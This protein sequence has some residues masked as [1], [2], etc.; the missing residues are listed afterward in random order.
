MSPRGLLV[1]MRCIVVPNDENSHP[2][3]ILECEEKVIAVT[4]GQPVKIGLF[5]RLNLG[6]RHFAKEFHSQNSCGCLV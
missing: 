1:V 2:L 4:L 3:S 6:K 5:E